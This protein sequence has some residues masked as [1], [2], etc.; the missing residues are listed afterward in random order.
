M[1]DPIHHP[2]VTILQGS[3]SWQVWSY[4][5]GCNHSR[6]VSAKR[7]IYLAFCHS[8]I[9]YLIRVE[10]GDNSQL[11]GVAGAVLDESVYRTLRM[12]YCIC[13]SASI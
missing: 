12:L 5:T 6:R 2:L 7:Q 11:Q 4:P 8:M 1:G 9:S 10:R 13:I 3:R